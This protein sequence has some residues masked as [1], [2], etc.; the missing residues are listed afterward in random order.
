LRNGY[1]GKSTGYSAAVRID[2]A[3]GGTFKPAYWGAD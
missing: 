3:M 1:S 2:A